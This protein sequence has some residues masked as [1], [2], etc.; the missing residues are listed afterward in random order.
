MKGPEVAMSRY[1]IDE[2]EWDEDDQ[3]FDGSNRRF[4]KKSIDEPKRSPMRRKDKMPPEERMKP[5]AKRNHKKALH[6]I[7]YE[8]KDD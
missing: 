4:A 1:N 2:T 5:K 3:I 8:W 6:R 7:K